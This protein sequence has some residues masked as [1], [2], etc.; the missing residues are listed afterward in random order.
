MQDSL[1]YTR[2]GTAEQES[3]GLILVTPAASTASKQINTPQPAHFHVAHSKIVSSAIDI[4]R[5]VARFSRDH[6]LVFVVLLGSADSK[7]AALSHQEL[8]LGAI[9]DAFGQ[10]LWDAAQNSAVHC[11][12]DNSAQPSLAQD[13]HTVPGNITGGSVSD[14]N[15]QLYVGR[16]PCKGETH[17]IRVPGKQ[18]LQPVVSVHNVHTLIEPIHDYTQTGS[19]T[20]SSNAIGSDVTTAPIALQATDS[21]P[22]SSVLD[23]LYVSRPSFVS[24]IDGF[25]V[26]RD[27]YHLVELANEHDSFQSD[28]GPSG[29]IANDA[30]LLSADSKLMR[31]RDQ[32]CWKSVR[33]AVEVIEEA[34]TRYGPHEI[35]LSFNGGKDCTVILHLYIAVLYKLHGSDMDAMLAAL[36]LP[37]TPQ[38]PQQQRH[39]P[40]RFPIPSIYVTDE[41]PFGQVERFVDDEIERYNLDLVRI[42]GPMK[43]AL[44][45]YHGLKNGAIKAIMVGTRRDDPHGGPLKPFT[46]CD[47]SWPQLMRIHPILDWT[48]HDIWT[49]LRAIN[50]PYCGLYDLGYTSLGGRDDTF[51]NPELRRLSIGPFFDSEAIAQWKENGP[52][53]L[54]PESTEGVRDQVARIV[55]ASRTCDGHE[56]ESDEEREA[57]LLDQLHQVD[58]TLD[59]LEEDFLFR[60]AWKLAGGE[61]E[62]CGRAK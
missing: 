48:Y 34:L 17:Y 25:Q 54:G 30:A 6:S 22:I 59:R 43:K 31:E 50:V 36:T 33:H 57:R 11:P 29:A 21:D 56:K 27:V 18:P 2:R 38:Q 28:K 32:E 19:T 35:S 9:A 49:F 37:D 10:E 44:F 26:M 20:A 7:G 24:P 14:E 51:P 3:V 8:V 53:G 60:P 46:P 1:P 42:P 58:K 15:K 41:K 4:T 5:A 16:A 40:Q 47:P 61:S 13:N 23:A 39:H 45:D 12:N 55:E 62:R 52:G